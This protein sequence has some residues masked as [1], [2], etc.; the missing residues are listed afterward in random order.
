MSDLP[1]AY[2]FPK[3][4]RHDGWTPTRQGIFLDA[5]AEEGSIRFAISAAG[6][7]PSGVYAARRR[8]PA[9]DLGWQA[10]LQLA[11]DPLFDQLMDRAIH[12]ELYH[13]TRAGDTTTRSRPNY[14][15]GLG[16]L[17]RIDKTP[18]TTEIGS[19]MRRWDEFLEIIEDGAEN[20]AVRGFFDAAN[21]G[22]AA[23]ERIANLFPLPEESAENEAPEF[24]IWQDGDSEWLCNFPP[25]EDFAGK[26]QG[27]FGDE[28][29]ARDLTDPEY[30]KLWRE[31]HA[32]EEPDPEKLVRGIAAREEWLAD[33]AEEG[34][35]EPPIEIK[36]MDGL[37]LRS[38]LRGQPA[39]QLPWKP[40]GMRCGMWTT[41][42]ASPSK[43]VA[44]RMTRSVV[45][46]RVS[47]T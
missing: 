24:E 14:R 2:E 32:V 47:T 45:S 18:R 27:T 44:S 38:H 41:A 19:I 20:A 13:T 6:M 46:L 34:S 7:G 28:D 21:L 5:L 40:G 4:R 36:S 12:G 30:A 37:R 26:E 23:S 11:R 9:F 17:D 22:P 42:F 16:L 10:A 8:F 33:D 1:P 35:D 29:Y 31:R 3:R 43:S 39:T 15:L 25:P